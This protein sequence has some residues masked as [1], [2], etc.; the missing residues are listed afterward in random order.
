MCISEVRYFVLIV[1]SEIGWNRTRSHAIKS[2][3]HRGQSLYV[4]TGK[5]F[6]M[7]L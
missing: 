1:Q 3:G 5:K 2:K 4:V 7:T 6:D